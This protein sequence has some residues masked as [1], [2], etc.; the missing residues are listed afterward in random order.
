MYSEIKLF[1]FKE[2]VVLGWKFI[3]VEGTF[4]LKSDA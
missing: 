2:N 1:V 3:V 4:I